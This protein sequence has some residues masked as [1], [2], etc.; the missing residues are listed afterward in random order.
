MIRARQPPQTVCQ[1]A[2]GAAQGWKG[3]QEGM[4]RARQPPQD[5]GGLTN[6]SLQVACQ[7]AKEA[8]R[9]GPFGSSGTKGVE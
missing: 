6:D 7:A 5:G 1:T 8:A 2:A 4:V 9:K 3:R